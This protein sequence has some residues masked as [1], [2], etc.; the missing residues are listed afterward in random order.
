[1]RLHHEHNH[2][3]LVVWQFHLPIHFLAPVPLMTKMMP[4]HEYYYDDP[5]FFRV[6][7]LE[8]QLAHFPN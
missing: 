3:R 6:E 1:M 8:R 2:W 7:G 4:P 5:V